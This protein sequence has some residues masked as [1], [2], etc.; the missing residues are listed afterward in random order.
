LDECANVESKR[1]PEKSAP[2]LLPAGMMGDRADIIF[3]DP[4]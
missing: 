2:A 3:A 4:R 1:G